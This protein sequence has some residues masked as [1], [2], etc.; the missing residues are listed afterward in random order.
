MEL[1]IVTKPVQQTRQQQPPAAL[2]QLRQL[3]PLKAVPL[4]RTQTRTTTLTKRGSDEL[5]LMQD[6]VRK[7]ARIFDAIEEKKRALHEDLKN[8]KSQLLECE[9]QTKQ[10]A[11][12]HARNSAYLASLR[13]FFDNVAK[14]LEPVN[15]ERLE[16]V[17]NTVKMAHVVLTDFQKELNT[18]NK[19][20]MTLEEFKRKMH[21]ELTGS[22]QQ[23]WNQRIDHNQSQELALQDARALIV[24][25]EEQ[26]I[27]A[28]QSLILSEQT[29]HCYQQSNYDAM[30][31][32]QEA[33]SKCDEVVY[34]LQVAED[35][36][37]VHKNEH[38]RAECAL[39]K[40][41]ESVQDD[42]MERKKRQTDLNHS[43]TDSVRAIE[44]AEVTARDLR[45]DLSDALQKNDALIEMD[46][47]K[48]ATAADLKH[49]LAETRSALSATL[50]ANLEKK[51][52][53]EV[54]LQH[55]DTTEKAL[56]AMCRALA[57]EK[58]RLTEGMQQHSQLTE[59]LQNLHVRQHIVQNRHNS[60]LEQIKPELAILEKSLRQA[61]TQLFE[62]TQE[63]LNT[64]KRVQLAEQER[65]DLKAQLEDYV[66]TAATLA[67]ECQV[68]EAAKVELEILELQRA[69][70]EV[71]K[72]RDE[73]IEKTNALRAQ[74]DDEALEIPR[75]EQT[76]M[77][78]SL[79]AEL[80]KQKAELQTALAQ[81]QAE[82]RDRIVELRCGDRMAKAI[83]KHSKKVET[84]SKAI[85]EAKTHPALS[86]SRQTVP[87]TYSM[88]TQ[89]SRPL[90]RISTGNTRPPMT[91][92]NAQPQTAACATQPK[93]QHSQVERAA[94]L[95][96]P[97][98]KPMVTDW[99][100]DN[101]W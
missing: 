89:H 17:S 68:R 56:D 47:K 72:E 24:S 85:A 84:L 86:E 80:Q 88:S 14:D 65:E 26:L 57:D 32:Y 3:Q 59:S 54:S 48:R 53:L 101:C 21:E 41:N 63:T 22:L 28:D 46:K 62:A 100:N 39:Q 52:E 20:L 51:S 40:E 49:K 2:N 70:A 38:Q 30:A 61:K 71:A 35:A 43:V 29:L 34:N 83:S 37:E 96:K 18:M 13:R 87:Q 42:I 45:R 10:E 11:E 67:Q 7:V 98:V 31:R 90:S 82:L 6:Q 23:G 60:T 8:K 97:P 95:K 15:D 25:L 50:S 66:V 77:N 74:V 4:E 64:S 27:S 9:N 36:L 79:K 19:E 58:H 78:K 12:S 1:E 91:R 44:A 16:S 81:E 93:Q 69:A 33:S 99:F 76:K 73:L 75:G 55:Q 94:V 5:A 92:G